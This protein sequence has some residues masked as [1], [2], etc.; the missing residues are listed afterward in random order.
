MP[1]PNKP[2]HANTRQ[3]SSCMCASLLFWTNFCL[4][5][6]SGSA[7]KV[8]LQFLEVDSLLPDS[9]GW[10]LDQTSSLEGNC[11]CVCL[12]TRA[13]VLGACMCV[14]VCVLLSATYW[15]ILCLFA[16]NYWWGV[17]VCVCVFYLSGCLSLC[18]VLLV[19]VDLLALSSS[20]CTAGCHTLAW[21]ERRRF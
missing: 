14:T 13:S 8:S 15:S 10:T 20:T 9:I 12:C 7:P 5:M 17:C 2:R 3:Q 6:W 21:E 18:L 1:T 4:P 19:S 16:R 11:G